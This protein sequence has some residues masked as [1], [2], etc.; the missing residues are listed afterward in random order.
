MRDNPSFEPKRRGVGIVDGGVFL[1]VIALGAAVYFTPLRSWLAQGQLIKEHLATF[2]LAAPW[3]FTFG[4]ALLTALGLPRLLLCSLGGL[5]FGFAWGLLWTQLGTVLGSYVL[6]LLVRWRGRAYTLDRYPKLGG[7]LR[8]MEG[9]GL[10]AVVLMRQLPLHGF[11]NTLLLGLAPVS[12]GEFL[13]GSLLGFLPL[14]LTACLLGA[15]LI[16]PDWLKAVQYVALALASSLALGVLLK[17]L[18]RRQGGA[19]G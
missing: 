12:H 8:N 11:Y 15:G 3:V 17:S 10:L 9:R 4:V 18:A 19:R 14:G 5:A 7:L 6:F 1:A 13:L 16:Q 2:G